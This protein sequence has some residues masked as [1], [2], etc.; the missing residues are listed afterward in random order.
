MSQNTL[1]EKK[2][3]T[4]SVSASED[5]EQTFLWVAQRASILNVFD[6]VNVVFQPEVP[7]FSFFKV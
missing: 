6:K 2:G 1:V 5:L 3:S 7:F 4:L